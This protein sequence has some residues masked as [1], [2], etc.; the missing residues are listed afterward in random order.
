MSARR[1]VC[2]TVCSESSSCQRVK[3]PKTHWVSEAAGLP[4][5]VEQEFEECLVCGRLEQ[6]FLRVR[7]NSCHQVESDLVRSLLIN[8]MSYSIKHLE[9]NVLSNRRKSMPEGLADRLY[10]MLTRFGS[11]KPSRRSLPLE[12][13]NSLTL[14]PRPGFEAR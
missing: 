7:C 11:K 10:R 2:T 12:L 14:P 13:T 8:S 6:G 5:Y 4:A 9:I 1:R 3:S